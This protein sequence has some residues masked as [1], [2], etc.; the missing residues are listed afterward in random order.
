MTSDSSV[1][2]LCGE[3][4]LRNESDSWVTMI[5]VYEYF[6]THHLAK[7]FESLFGTVTC[8]PGCFCMYRI[9]SHNDKSPILISPKIIKAYRENI[10]NTLHLKNLLSLGE[11][12]Y[13]TTL[14]LQKF[15][16]MKLKFIQEAKA[17]TSAPDTWRV[18]L[19]QRRRWINS[20]VH[21]LFELLRLNDLCGCF[22]F[23][24]RFIVF[25][26]LFSTLMAPAGFLF[27][28]YLIYSL[29]I[30]DSKSIPFVSIIMLVAIYGLQV[31]IF[32]LRKEWQHIGWM[33]IVYIFKIV[34]SCHADIYLFFT[35]IFLLEF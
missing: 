10:V 1:S 28:I 8:L 21:N 20:T 19:S 11:D 25:M 15:P 16:K 30:S 12:R 27:V 24:I 29:L 23:S 6:I 22:I 34:Y 13:L 4:L 14:M 31:I 33:F 17:K 26:D 2:G 9:F 5:Q 3:T 7:A 35:F 18:L 32:L